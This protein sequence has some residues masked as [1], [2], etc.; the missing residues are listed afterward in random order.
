MRITTIFIIVITVLLTIILMQ[1]T[2]PVTFDILFS[3][4]YISKLAALAT[5][6]AVAFILGVLVGRPKKA[7]NIATDDE[8]DNYTGNNPNT[9]SDEDRE[10]ISRP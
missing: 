5:F 6:G 7:R 4:F 8:D 1:N 3:T 2:E 10:Y 9:L